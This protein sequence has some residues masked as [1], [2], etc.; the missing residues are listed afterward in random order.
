MR[1]RGTERHTDRDETRGEK[2]GTKKSRDLLFLISA[3]MQGGKRASEAGA[4]WSLCPSPHCCSFWVLLSPDVSFLKVK[5]GLSLRP[6]LRG[7]VRLEGLLPAVEAHRSAS[8]ARHRKPV[9]GPGHAHPPQPAGGSAPPVCRSPKVPRTDPQSGVRAAYKGPAWPRHLL[10]QLF[11]SVTVANRTTGPQRSFLTPGPMK[12]PELPAAGARPGPARGC[13]PFLRALS[14]RLTSA[15][16][17]GRWGTVLRAAG[18]K[19]GL[20]CLP[21]WEGQK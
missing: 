17:G 19:R 14:P 15:L 13:L 10:V 5:E 1:H 8:P 9:L 18:T 20:S 7:Q 11:P 2:S 4:A 3:R 21:G 16:R 12:G 6:L